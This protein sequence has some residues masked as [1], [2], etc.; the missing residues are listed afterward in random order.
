MNA[1]EHEAPAV[2]LTARQQTGHLQSKDHGLVNKY[3]PNQ[4][5][6]SDRIWGDRSVVH[7]LY[8]PFVLIFAVPGISLK[9]STCL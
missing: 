2:T 7:M 5:A 6:R 1:A 3:L 8:G 9:L 4:A